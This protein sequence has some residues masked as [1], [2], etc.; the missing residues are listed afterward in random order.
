MEVKWGLNIPIFQ[1]IITV[2]FLVIDTSTIH[3]TLKSD[4]RPSIRI[5]RVYLCCFPL[6]VF[7][8]SHLKLKSVLGAL[9]HLPQQM[10]RSI[11]EIN[12]WGSWSSV[13]G[14]VTCS[15]V[16]QSYPL[17]SLQLQVEDEDWH[18]YYLS[19]PINIIQ[20]II[21]TLF[22]RQKEWIALANQ[23]CVVVSTS[24][25]STIIL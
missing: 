6:Y 18:W 25:N 19:H 17:Q 3:S 1:A 20:F 11:Q 22:R 21:I 16:F 24:K 9:N 8:R 2:E 14:E 5:W 23:Y 4:L 15:A 13:N 7:E 10:S 12:I